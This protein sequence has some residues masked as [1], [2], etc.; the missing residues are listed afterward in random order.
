MPTYIHELPDWPEFRWDSKRL[1]E[2]L[3][4]TVRHQGYLIGRIRSFGLELRG[5]AELRTL[6]EEVLK[7]SEIEGEKLNR[8]QVRSSLATGLGID[9]GALTP[10][11]RSA[12]GIVQVV[13]DATQN[14]DKPITRERLFGWHAALFPNGFSG[15]RKITVG[16][17]RT[18]EK[19]PMRVVTERRGK[20]SLVHFEAPNANLVGKEM[21]AFIDWFNR[22]QPGLDLVLKAAIAHLWFETIHPFEDGNGR[23]GRALADMLLA[24][25]EQSPQRFYSISAQIK[26]E[27]G[28]YYDHLEEIQK[29][30]LDITSYLEWFLE[31]LG[32]AFDG[33][34]T[35]LA[36][37]LRKA[38]FW[39]MHRKTRFNERQTKMINRMLDGIEGKLTSS[40]WAKMAKT[41]QDTAGRDIEGLLSANVLVREPGRGRSTS[42]ALVANQADILHAIACYARTFADMSVMKGPALPGAAERAERRQKIGQLADRIDGLASSEMD[43]ER[44]YREFESLLSVLHDAGFF[45]ENQLI[46]TLA[47]ITHHGGR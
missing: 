18:G 11:S 42:Y 47:F 33:A 6:T 21:D 2:K 8:D 20:P 41:S 30:D 15:L 16:A 10:A 22:D 12:E 14:Y 46:Q 1:A 38:Q 34:E 13:L 35:I 27:Q 17:W 26:V 19:G 7:S 44:R 9:I 36:D 5:E 45:P 37:V 3:A 28:K 29:G 24:R 4:G 43:A 32:R 23:I 40:K 31:C 25:S 39:E